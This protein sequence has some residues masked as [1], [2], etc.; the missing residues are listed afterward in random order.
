MI[1]LAFPSCMVETDKVE[2]SDTQLK[3]YI[4]Y[5]VFPSRINCS[6]FDTLWQSLL[7]F[8]KYLWG[9]LHFTA[10]LIIRLGPRDWVLGQYACYGKRFRPLWNLA[11]NNHLLK[12]SSL[13]FSC[14][15]D[16]GGHVFQVTDLRDGEV[17]PVTGH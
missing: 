15:S 12:N 14:L 3:R 6:P 5:E 17:L 10:S 2:W 4:F 11:P 8:S 9:P 1:L 16:L 13:S 7:V